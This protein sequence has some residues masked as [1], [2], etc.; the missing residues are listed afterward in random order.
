VTPGSTG[1]LL[2]GLDGAGFNRPNF[3]VDEAIVIM[4]RVPTD[5][6]MLALYTAGA[7]GTQV[8]YP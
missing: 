8:T 6:E 7:A 3:D 4:G 1:Q 5:A 2:F